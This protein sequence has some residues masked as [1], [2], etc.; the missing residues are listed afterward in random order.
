MWHD[1]EGT[2]AAELAHQEAFMVNAT[3]PHVPNVCGQ[4]QGW[5]VSVH[6]QSDG[7]TFPDPADPSKR[8]AGTLLC[9]NAT[10]V[11]ANTK[12]AINAYRH[13]WL[14]LIECPITDNEHAN[15]TWQWGLE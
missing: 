14:H 13:E 1:F 8:W 11:V 12:W 3:E 5:L 2:A 6:P 7:R 15:W 9:A 10:L 4:V